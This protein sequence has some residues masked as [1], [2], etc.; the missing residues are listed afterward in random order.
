[1]VGIASM[2]GLALGD[3]VIGSV[4]K[5][6]AP[7]PPLDAVAALGVIAIVT[8]VVLLACCLPARSAARVDPTTA[9][10]AL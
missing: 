1:M 5:L 8:M 6:L 10:R 2:L 9:L 7:M 3:I 4:S